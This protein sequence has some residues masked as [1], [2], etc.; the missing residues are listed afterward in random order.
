MRSPTRRTGVFSLAGR[1]RHIKHS[2][3]ARSLSGPRGLSARGGPGSDSQRGAECLSQGRRPHRSRDPGL[4]HRCGLLFLGVVHGQMLLSILTPGV[5]E[6]T[7]G[8]SS[9]WWELLC[10]FKGLLLPSR[11]VLFTC[12]FSALARAACLPHES[13]TETSW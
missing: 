10:K 8:G 2:Q 11:S 1:C 12:A 3:L 6:R 9:R 13:P 4:D 7:Q 5:R